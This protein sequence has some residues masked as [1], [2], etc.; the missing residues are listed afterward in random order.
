MSTKMQDPVLNGY[1]QHIPIIFECQ[2]IFFWS[3]FYVFA[4]V[5][6]FRQLLHSEKNLLE[7]FFEYRSYRI[8]LVCVKT[9]SR[10]EN[11]CQWGALKSSF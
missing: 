2:Q 1:D 3:D 8:M 5:L 4:H 7:R 10:E 9:T 11:V 6:I